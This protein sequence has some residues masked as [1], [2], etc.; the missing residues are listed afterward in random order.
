MNKLETFN[1]QQRYLFG[2]AYRMLGSVQDA[3]DVLQEAFIRWD[4]VPDPEVRNAK[5]FLTTIATRLSIDQLRKV[6]RDREKYE[7]PWLP[8]PW[9]Q[10]PDSA[11]ASSDLADSLSTAFLL[12]LERLAPSERA[13]LLLKDVFD[14]PYEEIASMLQK[15]E[16]NCRQMVKRARD[17]L[18]DD[19]VRFDVPQ[20]EHQTL[21]NAFMAA[22]KARDYDQ[23]VAVLAEDAQLISDHGGKVA[24]NKRPILGA[25]KIAR[26]ILG[27]Q[28]RFMSDQHRSVITTINGKP[29]ILS[30]EGDT[31]DSIMTI[32]LKQ[33]KIH[34]IYTTRNPDKLP[35]NA[36]N[37]PN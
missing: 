2:I 27:L 13:A 10:E 21:L 5:A 32:T 23:F 12:V 4:A 3:E 19:N 29:G 22:S 18:T 36:K 25:D 24:A 16:P 34:R 31:P 26:F 37:L 14:Y 20:E 35:I 8:E 33:G 15:S 1:E 6:K 28:E 11:D 30:F 9:L 17:R 7:G